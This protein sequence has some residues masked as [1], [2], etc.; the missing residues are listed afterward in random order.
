MQ[1]KKY[2]GLSD[3]ERSEIEILLGRQCGIREIARALKRSPNTISREVMVNSV[4]GQYIALKAKQ[5]ARISRK[6]R[7]YQWRKI[8]HEPSL[9][10]FIIEKLAPPDH[11]SPDEISGYLKR[12]Q[13]ALPYVS[14]PQIYAWLYSSYGQ[15]YCQH[16][17]SKRYHPKR[18]VRVQKRVLIPDRASI[19][20]R[21]AGATH[22]TRYGH[23]EG[24]TVVSG[25]KT[26]SKAALAVFVERRTRLVT[27][28]LI[29]NLRPASFAYA[30]IAALAGKQALT[31][32]LD[33]GVENTRHDAITRA[34]GTKAYF[35]DPYSSWQKGS[36]EQ[37]NKML[38]RYIPKGTDL[39]TLSQTQIDQYVTS[40]NNKPRRCLGYY[41]ALEL[42]KEKGV[43]R[44]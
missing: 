2:V 34:T 20:Q 38:R 21:P 19:A 10:T 36:V 32:S 13:T 9:R 43:L 30:A 22:R 7:R 15:S 18:R 4:N 29:P 17:Y 16:L 24:D 27:A 6:S 25:K 42:S 31:L 35:C 1:P 8:E 40:I 5:K 33:N 12:R 28:T 44:K 26:G 23:W 14:S 41:S 3:A 37:V 11:W 39:A